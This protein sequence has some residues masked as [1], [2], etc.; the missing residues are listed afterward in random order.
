MQHCIVSL[1]RSVSKREKMPSGRFAGSFAMIQCQLR[2]VGDSAL[3]VHLRWRLIEGWWGRR[4]GYKC[5]RRVGRAYP[6]S[7]ERE[8]LCVLSK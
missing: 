1:Y 5:A 2:C 6:W 8:K 7:R 4:E 3:G